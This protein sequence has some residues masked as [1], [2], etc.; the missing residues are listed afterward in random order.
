MAAPAGAVALQGV[1][2]SLLQLGTQDSVAQ[3][4][5]RQMDGK[6][7]YNHTRDKW[8]EWDGTRWQIEARR[9][10]LIS[11]ATLPAL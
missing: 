10:R 7:L 1:E 11:P 3:I 6:M 2:M 4:F 9:R 8:L 5:A